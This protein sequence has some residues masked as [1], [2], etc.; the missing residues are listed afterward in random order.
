[1][2]KTLAYAYYCGETPVPWISKETADIGTDIAAQ[3]PENKAWVS[4]QRSVSRMETAFALSCI[5]YGRKASHEPQEIAVVRMLS[6]YG[7][8][9]FLPCRIESLSKNLLGNTK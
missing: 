3:T 8:R 9:D 5:K 4:H 7:E 1:M 6:V 2:W